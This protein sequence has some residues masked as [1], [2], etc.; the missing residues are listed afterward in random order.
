MFPYTRCSPAVVDLSAEECF[1]TL[2]AA[3]PS[4]TRLRAAIRRLRLSGHM[5]RSRTPL[6]S[7]RRDTLQT[8]CT[9]LPYIRCLSFSAADLGPCSDAE[10]HARVETLDELHVYHR[11]ICAV[12]DFLLSFR[13]VSRLE[14]RWMPFQSIVRG[15]PPSQLPLQVESLELSAYE[16]NVIQQLAAVIDLTFIHTLTVR[17]PLSEAMEDTIHSLL[18]NLTSLSYETNRREHLP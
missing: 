18:P 12:A 8:V 2:A 6:P 9:L 17:S 3:L 1:P 10:R 5:C 14:I 4:S 7:L 15:D 13:R 16:T 11:D